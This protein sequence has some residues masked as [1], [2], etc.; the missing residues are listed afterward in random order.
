MSDSW[1][2][3]F[4]TTPGSVHVTDSSPEG[5][6]NSHAVW[7]VLRTCATMLQGVIARESESDHCVIY[8]ILNCFIVICFLK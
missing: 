6:S 8:C 4:L 2:A 5:D 7:S 3:H 1:G